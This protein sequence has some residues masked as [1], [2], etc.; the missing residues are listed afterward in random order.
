MLTLQGVGDDNATAE[1]EPH[2]VPSTREQGVLLAPPKLQLTAETDME[3][4]RRKQK[5]VVVRHSSGDR[6]VATI[7]VV[8]PG[9]KAVRNPLRAFVEKAAELLENGIHLLVLDLHP[10][11][12]RPLT[13]AAYE[14][15]NALR[16][17]VVPMAVG[18]VL[19][20]TARL[21]TISD[22]IRA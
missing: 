9:N 11:S 18:D 1:R 15:G 8:S 12:E 4:Y 5:A 13:L 20:T 3:F 2:D 17:Y 16:T 22:P 6:V 21:K 7:E 14:A 10:P 19:L